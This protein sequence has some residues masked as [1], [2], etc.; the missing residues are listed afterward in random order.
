MSG[1]LELQLTCGALPE[2]DIPFFVALCE[3]VGL[4]PLLIDHAHPRDDDG[5]RRQQPSAIAWLRADFEE[6]MAEAT[7]LAQWLARAGMAV[8]G[9]KVDAPVHD[10]HS[11]LRAGQYFEW[12]GKL[13][14]LHDLSALQRLCDAHG[15]QLSRDI[16]RDEADTCFVT[17]RSREPL[18]AFR[19]CVA[20]LASQLAHEGWPLLRQDAEICLHDSRETPAADWLSP[21]LLPPI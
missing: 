2:A 18:A 3:Q 12:R 6:T 16:L 19:A 9:V 5:S 15:A 4:R 14:Q 21:F 8:L 10:A 1:M 11:L 7:A 20:A 13:Q 17:L